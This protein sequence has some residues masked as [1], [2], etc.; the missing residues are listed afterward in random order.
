MKNGIIYLSIILFSQGALAQQSG[1]ELENWCGTAQRMNA[2]LENPEQAQSLLKDEMTRQKELLNGSVAPKGTIYKIP[3]VFHILHNNG[4]ENV[5]EDQ[6]FNALDV[7]NRDF[8]LQNADTADV[9]ALFQPIMGDVEIE[10]VLATKA[11]NGECFRGYTRT[12]SPL[13]SQGDDGGAQ[14]D[15]IRNGN[16]VYQG[17]WPSNRYLNIFVIDDAGGA[18]GYTNYPNDWGGTDM[19]N[20]IWILHTQFGEIGTSSLGGGRSLTHECGHWLNL[21][22]TW[23]NSNNPGLASNCN[24]DDLVSDTPN[25]RGSAGGCNLGDNACGSVAN[26]QNYMDYSLSCQSMFTEGQVDRMR[27]AIISSVGGRNNLWTQQNLDL[28][29]ATGTQYLCNA[30]FTANKTAICAGETVQFTDQSFNVVNGWTW[31]FD[32]GNPATS[33]AQ[34]PSVTY[35]TPGLYQV[36]LDAS[37][38]VNTDL[39]AKV[40]YIRVLPASAQLPFLETF[41][42]FSTLTNIDEWEV[43]NEGGNG[44]ELET[45]TG[46]TGTKCARLINNGQPDGT[47]DELSANALDLSNVS[48]LTLSFRY[49]Y[50]RKNS[51]DDDWFRVFVTNDCGDNWAV[52]KT[53]HGFQL[54]TLTQSSSF[55]PSSQADWTTVHMTNI[56]SSYWVDDFRYKFSFEAGGGNNFFID[57]INIYEGAPSDDL[58][59]GLEEPGGLSGLIVYPNPVEDELSVAFTLNNAQSSRLQIQ[60]VSGKITQAHVVH[61]NAGSNTVF[62]DTKALAQGMY[63]L[64]I[65]TGDT[66]QTVRFVVK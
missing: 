16:D 36:V 23:G 62:I 66:A 59:V 14:V 6:I 46:H 26:I 35:D 51:S 50:K 47:L 2:M 9:I 58:I 5:E 37:D 60:D 18:G 17:N 25:C 64:T 49:A 56:T 65:Q 57:N 43:I 3:I 33:T 41:E 21:R 55:T 8:R 7:I 34:N 32:G 63:F 19:S 15:A 12:E 20:G 40:A 54:S 4:S 61:A 45:T 13:T 1:Q 44:F 11:P 38:G 22:H 42:N 52:R 30:E 28:T 10:F 24:E 31:A 48:Q 29:G 27:D 53:L 39:E